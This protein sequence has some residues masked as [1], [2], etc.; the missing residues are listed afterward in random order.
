[1]STYYVALWVEYSN[2]N[3]GREDLHVEAG[4]PSDAQ[5][6]ASSKVSQQGSKVKKII[7]TEQR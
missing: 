4:S 1:M 3:E 6:E 5:A 2:G 7:L